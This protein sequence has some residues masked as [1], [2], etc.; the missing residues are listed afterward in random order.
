MYAASIK[1]NFYEVDEFTRL[2]KETDVRRRYQDFGAELSKSEDGFQLVMPAIITRYASYDTAQRQVRF[3]LQLPNRLLVIDRH[4]HWPLEA[5]KKTNIAPAY[6]DLAHSIARRVFVPSVLCDVQYGVTPGDFIYSGTGEPIF[7]VTTRRRDAF[8]VM[9]YADMPL[10]GFAGVQRHT[11]V[12]LGAEDDL[13]RG[14]Y[15]MFMPVA[16]VDRLLK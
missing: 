8:Y 3:M 2:I 11:M 4:V 15:M 12:K 9:F 16:L 10:N 13:G 6:C 1:S 7:K 14:I 5:L